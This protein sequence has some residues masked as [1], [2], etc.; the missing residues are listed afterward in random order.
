MTYYE[1]SENVTITKKRALLEVKNHGAS[2]SEFFSDCG[3]HA[4]YNAQTVLNWLGY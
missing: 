1:S 4:S 3:V 2:T